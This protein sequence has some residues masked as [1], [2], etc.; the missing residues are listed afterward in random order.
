MQK[1]KTQKKVYDPLKIS[2]TSNVILNIVLILLTISAIL[3]FLFVV[4]ISI[5]DEATIKSNGYSLIPEKFSLEA[6][7]FIFKS[8]GQ[9]ARS[10]K[11]Q[12]LLQ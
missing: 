2:K 3:P 12:L 1:E 8:G 4:M 5:T 7:K 6:Y 11:I 9:I 10:Y